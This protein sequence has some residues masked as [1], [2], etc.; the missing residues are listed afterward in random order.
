MFDNR[1]FYKLFNSR[2]DSQYQ[3][4]KEQIRWIAEEMKVHKGP[5]EARLR[6]SKTLAGYLLK[7]IR[8]EEK[9][10]PEYYMT[11]SA[12]QLKNDQ[13]ILL[14]TAALLQEMSSQKSCDLQARYCESYQVHIP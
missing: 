4:E 9:W 2:M 1:S 7:L 13:K 12:E 5:K 3:K 11:I 10:D 8:W 14:K 6:Y